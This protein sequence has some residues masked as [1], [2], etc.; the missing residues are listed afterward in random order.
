MAIRKKTLLTII[1]VCLGL[2]VV[3]VTGAGIYYFRPSKR[4]V[5]HYHR[6]LIY[7]RQGKFPAAIFELK[8]ALAIDPDHQT[9]HFQLAKAYAGNKNTE[10]SIRHLKV[11]LTKW[12]GYVDALDLL[13]QLY[14]VQK[15]D[16][17]ALETCEEILKKQPEH[18][19]ATLQRGRIYWR[20]KKYKKAESDFKKVIQLKPKLAGAYLYLS[21]LYWEQERRFDALAVLNSHLQKVD[22]DHFAVRLQ[23]AEYYL[24]L[25][26]FKK[27]LQEYRALKKKYPQALVIDPGL[28]FTAAF[29]GESRR[30]PDRSRKSAGQPR[31]QTARSQAKVHAFLHARGRIV[32]QEEI[33]RSQ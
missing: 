24:D 10:E 13:A 12:P 21:G 8:A 28:A 23:L 29:P 5:R 20:T 31:Q 15:K 4:V 2:A 6:G 33:Y 1:L 18:A 3:M 7:S 25:Q 14:F 11:I 16:Q 19:S 17:Q 32:A 26:K 22:A 9:V 27:A 30:G